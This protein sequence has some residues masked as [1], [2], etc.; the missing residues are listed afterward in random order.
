MRIGGRAGVI[1]VVEDEWLIRAEIVDEFKRH[2]WRVLEASTGEGAIGVLQ[3]DEPID[4]VMT[5]IQLGGYLNGWDVAEASRAVRPG[6]AVVYVSGNPANPAR[7][8]CDSLFLGKPY[9]SSHVL[10]ACRTL[11][12]ASAPN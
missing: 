11:V 8:V 4:I 1:L 10:E 9:R 6:I 2:G 7:A 12:S 5:D 3:T